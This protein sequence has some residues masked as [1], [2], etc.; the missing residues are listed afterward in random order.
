MLLHSTLIYQNTKQ[1]SLEIKTALKVI[2]LKGSVFFKQLF[3]YATPQ[4]SN[5]PTQDNNLG[6]SC[7]CG[8]GFPTQSPNK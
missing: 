4:I 3:V 7:R 5:I 6:K 2:F 8:V 1:N